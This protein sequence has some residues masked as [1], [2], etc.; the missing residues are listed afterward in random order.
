MAHAFINVVIP[1]ASK[2]ADAVNEALHR[3]TDPRFGNRPKDAIGRALSGLGIHFMTITVVD[4]ICPAERDRAPD[5]QPP[6]LAHADA[7][8]AIEI[9][10]DHGTGETLARLSESMGNELVQLLQ[11]AGLSVDQESLHPYLMQHR[12]VIAAS[13]GCDA[14]GQVFTGSP[15]MTVERIQSERDLAKRIGKCIED[16]QKVPTWH[17]RS[18]R[19]RLDVLRKALWDEGTWK[20]AFVPE[21]APCLEG[22]PHNR[23]R[24]DLSVANPQA[25][26]ALLTILI[27]LLWPL[28]LPFALIV[29]VVLALT[30]RHHGAEAAA[31]WTTDAIVGLLSGTVVA[32]AV[33]LGAAAGWLRAVLVGLALIAAALVAV[34]LQYHVPIVRAALTSEVFVGLLAGL[35]LVLTMVFA[36]AYGWLRG[37]LT[38]L[39]L[40]ALAVLVWR[41]YAQ[42][43]DALSNLFQNFWPIAAELALQA[44]RSADAFV[45]ALAMTLTALAARSVVLWVRLALI[46]L[47]ALVLAWWYADLLA[48]FLWSAHVVAGLLIGLFV[49]LAAFFV[50][51][52]LRLRQLER[53]DPVED[54]TPRPDHVRA[55]MTLENQDGCVQNH[56]ASVSRLKPGLLRRLT[57]RLTFIIVGTGKFVGRP[58]FL[59][60]NGVIHFARWMRLPGTDQL[61]FW[62][63]YDGTW[64]SYVADFIADAPTGVTGIWS[65]CVGFPRTRA[66][67]GKGA[68]DRD[69][70]V[71][72][73]RRQQQPTTFWYSAYRDLT[74]ERIRINAA[75][76]QG[77]AS[78]ESDADV[79]DWFTLFGSRPAPAEALRISQIPTLVLGGLSSMP[80]ATCHAIR[81][82]GEAGNCK[83][84]LKAA[85][86]VA[87][88][89]EALPGQ[90]SAVVVALSATGLRKLNVPEE[91]L[92]TF[93]VAFQQGMWPKWRARQLGDTGDSAPEQWQ[94]GNQAKP[95]DALLVVYGLSS[96]DQRAAEGKLLAIAKQCKHTV[97]HSLPLAPLEKPFKEPFGFADGISQPVIQGTT[98]GRTHGNPNDLVAA[99]E[100]VLGYPD[101]LGEIPPSPSISAAND[102]SHL[103]PDAGPNPFRRRP[104]FSRYEGAGC[105]DLGA[106][107]TFLVVRQ[108]WQDVQAF[109]AWLER[110][111]ERFEQEK[112]VATHQGR[113][114]FVW[115]SPGQYN[116]KTTLARP[117][118]ENIL[119]TA[120]GTPEREMIKHA[121]AAKMIGRWKDGTSL[122]RHPL[123]PGTDQAPPASPDNDFLLGAEDPSGFACPFGAHIRRANP[124]DTRFPEQAAKTSSVNRRRILPQQA[125]EIDSVN[126]HRILRVGRA[127]GADSNDTNRGLLFM[128]LN[129]DIE[130]QF[131]FIQKTWLLNQNLHGLEQEPDPIMGHGPRVFTIPT[132][133]RPLR[134]EIDADFV[135]LIGGGYFFLPGRAVLRYLVE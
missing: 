41:Q 122:V 19:Q 81:L 13:W 113:T 34:S 68:E 67:L 52:L 46:A 7:H 126:R 69:R 95:V 83:R 47:G 5:E 8:L 63:N 116:A 131:E 44:L 62:S 73:A 6:A 88:Y 87:T 54:Q 9:S 37:L 71:R 56:L 23:W 120:S 97:I 98:R 35:V 123:M 45:W 118:P 36:A 103:L 90:K 108:L 29:V 65:N 80:F 48:E 3:L 135:K 105:R 25:W 86:E 127:Y 11:L 132:P 66:L 89:G 125:A 28:Y 43:L 64:E 112:V 12:R 24:D 61:L 53:T 16:E 134:L 110:T 102:P 26:K 40:V 121:I 1:F 119:K 82:E 20:W 18:L 79:R 33:V 94:W 75:I 55:L 27:Q 129:A 72:W 76:R 84:W 38:A 14:L 101:N 10:A 104:E 93:P 128:C 22:D 124:R 42:I 99:G 96:E 15:G 57:L 49:A 21:P 31:I 78:A 130:R 114:A 50:L 17:E 115:G 106:D 133:T 117:R 60:K 91:A 59:G 107:G 70:L 30:S 92:E 74:A 111:A 2:R 77:L 85:A 32:L 39:I 100:I 4:P 51:A 109:R 58:G